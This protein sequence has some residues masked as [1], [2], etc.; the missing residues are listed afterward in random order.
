MMLVGPSALSGRVMIG[1]IAMASV[2]NKVTG[3]NCYHARSADWRPLADLHA[4]FEFLGNCQG[5][6]D[7]T[8]R[9]G[10][11]QQFECAFPFLDVSDRQARADNYF[12]KVV[13]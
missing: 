2:G 7:Q 11:L 1:Q 10:F 3:V 12:A 13:A 6:R 4:G 5:T 8:Q 9:L